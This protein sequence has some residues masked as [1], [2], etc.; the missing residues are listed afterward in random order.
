LA[1]TTHDADEGFHEIHLTGKQL[2]FLFMATTV[3]SVVIFLCGVLV[4]RGVR[5]ERDQPDA[6]DDT[7]AATA[8][9]QANTPSAPGTAAIE[10]PNPPAEEGELSYKKRLESEGTPTEKLK[11]KPAEPRAER[12]VPSPAPTAGVASGNAS[13]GGRPGTWVVQLVAIRDRSAATSIVERLKR[14]GYPAFLVN[15]VPGSPAPVF[16][17]QVGRY[18]DRAEAERVSDR[19]KK[20]ERFQPWIQR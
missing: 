20:E 12:P 5:S 13:N 1:D 18:N 2:V 3:I 8:P 17:V 11:P 9:A 10:P 4:G 16:K 6:V 7:I 15:P 19:L 14:K